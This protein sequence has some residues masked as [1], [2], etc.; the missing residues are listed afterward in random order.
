M[1]SRREWLALLGLLG[2]CFVVAAVGSLLTT[3]ALD[4]W[5]TMLR[6]PTWTPPNWIFGP[7]WTLLYASMAVAAWLVWR[8]RESADVM[9]PLALFVTQLVFNLGWS[10]VFFG[11][12]LPGVAFIEIG[13]LWCTILAT[14]IAFWRISIV[15][16]WLFL[17]Y[18]VWVSFALA[19]NFSIWRLN[20]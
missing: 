16:G 19:L 6:K 15:A 20:S 8:K 10:W 2:S 5:Y 3:P 12:R 13:V 9:I 7:V 4:D 17:P 11:L 1:S 14:L 18:L